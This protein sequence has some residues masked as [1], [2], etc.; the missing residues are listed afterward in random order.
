MKEPSIQKK[1][2][3]GHTEGNPQKDGKMVYGTTLLDLLDHIYTGC[4]LLWIKT[5]GVQDSSWL[6]EPLDG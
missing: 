1:I 2:L 3:K 6:V 5:G 4:Y